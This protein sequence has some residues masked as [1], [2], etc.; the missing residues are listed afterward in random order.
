MSVSRVTGGNMSRGQA[1]DAVNDPLLPLAVD[2]IGIDEPPAVAVRRVAFAIV[3]AKAVQRIGRR[4]VLDIEEEGPVGALR[5]EEPL[6]VLARLVI[7][8]EVILGK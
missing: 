3:H 5:L 8:E 2:E 7:L 1:A 4:R 6:G